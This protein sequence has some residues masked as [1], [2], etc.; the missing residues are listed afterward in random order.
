MPAR[1]SALSKEQA[2][3]ARALEQAELRW[4]TLADGLEV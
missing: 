1:I 4:L 3:I 2:D